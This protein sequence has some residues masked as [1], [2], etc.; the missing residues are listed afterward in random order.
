M[1]QDKKGASAKSSTTGKKEV[2]SISKGR[3][4][5]G[6]RETSK[7]PM[8]AYPSALRRGETDEKYLDVLNRISR[9]AAG[10]PKGSKKGKSK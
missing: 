5:K 1:K 7:D 3:A 4:A 9:A 10:M 6:K 2:S 8:L